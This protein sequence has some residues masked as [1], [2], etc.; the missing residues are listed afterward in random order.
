MATPKIKLSKKTIIISLSIIAFLLIGFIIL[1]FA[2]IKPQHEKAISSYSKALETYNVALA[3]FDELYKQFENENNKLSTEFDDLQD[4]ITHDGKPYDESTITKAN[5]AI[6]QGKIALQPLP[7]L[8]F[9]REVKRPNDFFFLQIQGV[10]KQEKQVIEKTEKLNKL[11]SETKIPDYTEVIKTIDL[12]QTN[13]ENSIRQLKQVTA[14]SESFVLSRI[15]EIKEAAGMIDIIALTEDTDPENYIG[16][17]GWYTSKVI[18]RHK[19]VEHYG[20]SSGL[21]TLSEV[22]NPAGGCI[23]T[24]TT[25]EDA[26]RRNIELTEMEGTVKSP[27]EHFVCGTMVVRISQDMKTSTQKQLLEMILNSLLRL[28]D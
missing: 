6:N 22:G 11:V 26:E 25:V 1:F 9:E 8:D 2:Y 24:Y 10:Y 19:D 5:D 21:L 14:P 12:A 4:V 7:S 27:G 17:K 28:E 18:F 13:L 23:E 20:L 16:K 3:D 15:T